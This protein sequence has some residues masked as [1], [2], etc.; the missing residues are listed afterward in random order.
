MVKTERNIRQSYKK[1]KNSEDKETR[2]DEKTYIKI[3]NEYNRFLMEK[4][5]EGFEVTLPARM[6]VL[7]IIGT[8]TKI[9]FNSDGIPNLPPDWVKTKALWES[10]PEAKAT[11]KLVFH[12][13]EHTDG[14]RYKI[15]WS[16][17]RVP[18]ENKTLYGFR[19]TRE[20][21]RAINAL[22]NQGKEYFVK[23]K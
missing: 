12:L 21:K 3:A 6:G 10:N 15:L 22:A 9:K 17:T 2:V 8:K 14:I 7:S 18:I 11:K 19:L 5:L 16:K 23:N 13:N 4:V 1:Y 20:H